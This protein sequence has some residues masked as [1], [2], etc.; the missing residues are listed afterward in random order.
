MQLTRG[1]GMRLVRWCVAPL[2]FVATPGIA[3]A[4]IPDCKAISSSFERLACYD[5][6]TPPVSSAVQKPKPASTADFYGTEEEQMKQKL[7]P[8]CKGC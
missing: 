4:Q 2:L 6:L 1:S 5:K 3:L 8:I 7:R